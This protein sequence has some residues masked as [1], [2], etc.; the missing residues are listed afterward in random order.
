MTDSSQPLWEPAEEQIANAAMT[1]FRERAASTHGVALHDYPSLHQWSVDQPESFW[2]LIWDFCNVTGERRGDVLRSESDMQDCRFFPD[3]HLNFAE[4][5]LRFGDD[6]ESFVGVSPSD[7]SL[8]HRVF[9]H[10]FI[11]HQRH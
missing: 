11:S 9:D 7:V 2:T 8:V 1:R 10:L 3:S 6:F 5:L 4:N